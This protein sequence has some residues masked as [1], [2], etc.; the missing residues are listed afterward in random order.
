[1][2][3]PKTLLEDLSRHSLACGSQT[4]EVEHKDDGEWVF[5]RKGGEAIRVAKF[6]RRSSE[7]KELRENLDAA[8]KKP[9]K[10]AIGGQVWL[11]NVAVF[12][13]SGEAAFRVSIDPAPKLDPSAA[14][15][16]TKNRDSSWRTFTTTRKFTEW[17]PRNRTCS[18]TF[19]PPRRPFTT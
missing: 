11:L 5:I 19:R 2:G 15:R 6:A 13:S 14:P 7:A 9:V 4:I 8:L 18:V 17:R 3:K 16:F 10:T 1:M 12:D